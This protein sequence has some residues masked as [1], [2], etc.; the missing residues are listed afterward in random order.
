MASHRS[1]RITKELADIY[2]DSQSQIGAEPVSGDEDITHLRGSFPGPPGTPYEGGTYYIDIR[3]PLEYPFKP[4]VMKFET[5]IWHPNVSSQTGAICLDTLASAWSPVL[6]VKSSLLSLQS[7]LNTPEPKDPQDAE[8]ANMLLHRPK[9]FER[10][11]QQWAVN[12]A[13]APQKNAGEGSRDADESLRQEQGQQ[14]DDLA[15]YDGYNKDLVDRFCSMG[16]DVERVVGAFKYVGIDRL[17]GEDY[18]LDE[19][20]MGDITAR[21]LGEP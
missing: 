18:E 2:A 16:F 4:P 7:L 6:T 10:V 12:Y 5:K 20:E 9:E 8:V 21:L 11:A 14:K 13:G 15:K 3:I 17:D 1:R 19:E